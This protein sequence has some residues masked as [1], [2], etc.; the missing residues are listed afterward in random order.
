M[1]RRR[2]EIATAIRESDLLVFYVSARSIKPEICLLEVDY[3]LDQHI[4]ILVIM[5]DRSELSPGLHMSL[6]SKQAIERFRYSE[7]AYRMR[8]VRYIRSRDYEG[9]DNEPAQYRGLRSLIGGC[10][11][12]SMCR[13]KSPKR[14]AHN[15]NRP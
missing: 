10:L 11:I 14:S 5:L 15:C 12:C 13:T 8:L 6:K 4:P 9:D 7:S 3:A 2:E 1:S